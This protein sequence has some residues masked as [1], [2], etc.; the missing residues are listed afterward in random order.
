MTHLCVAQHPSGRHE[1]RVR[2]TLDVHVPITRLRPVRGCNP[3]L[4]GV[5]PVARS[6]LVRPPIAERR[7]RSAPYLQ[8]ASGECHDPTFLRIACALQTR[9]TPPVGVV[10]RA[11][12][13]PRRARAGGRTRRHCCCAASHRAANLHA[14]CGAG[15]W[16]AQQRGKRHFHQAGTQGDQRFDR[17]RGHRQA[18]RQQR[19]GGSAAGDRRAGGA[20]RRRSGPGAGAWPAERR[21]HAGRAQCLHHGGARHG[22]GGCAGG[23]AAQRGCVQDHRCAVPGRRHRRRGGCASAAAVRFRRRQHDCRQRQR[24]ARR[25]GGKDRAQWQPHHE[26]ALGDRGG[27]HGRDGQCGL[28]ASPVS[29]VQHALRHL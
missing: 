29:G 14:G 25:S 4:T 27:A 13:Q 3:A 26:P 5:A 7:T 21:H 20:C 12:A 22:V 24:I 19:C 9:N 11:A 16:R 28:P 17:G 8:P 23:V 18:A 2:I 6:R 10:D 1:E 15:A